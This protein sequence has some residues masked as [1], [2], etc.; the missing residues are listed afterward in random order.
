MLILG[1]Q[2]C[3]MVRRAKSTRKYQLMA[4]AHSVSSRRQSV[5]PQH[6]SEEHSPE[7]SSPSRQKPTPASD[8]TRSE[9]RLPRR[10]EFSR[11]EIPDNTPANTAKFIELFNHLQ[12]SYKDIA[13]IPGLHHTYVYKIIRFEKVPSDLV[14]SA[15]ENYSKLNE[16]DSNALRISLL[17][18][19]ESLDEKSSR[20][21]VHA[22][23][24]VI[25]DFLS[26]K[27]NNEETF[28]DATQQQSGPKSV[29]PVVIN[30]GGRN[31]KSR[32][33]PR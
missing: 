4:N 20:Q 10:K 19:L 29:E 1:R 27:N 16:A 6:R 22:V 24:R 9:P 25:A 32:H 5:T 30:T 3:S 33:L 7:I 17:R 18:S 14:V 28:E 15:L 12:R 26:S 21:F 13:S 2:E 11:I 23:I 31:G 8:R